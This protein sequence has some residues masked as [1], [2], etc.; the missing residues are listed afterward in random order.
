MIFNEYHSIESLVEE[1]NE[2]D[3]DDRARLAGHYAY[4]CSYKSH[5][6]WDGLPAAILKFGD[7]AFSA[8]LDILVE[9]GCDF[10]Y[11]DA[12]RW[13][14]QYARDEAIAELD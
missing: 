5:G 11:A 2:Y 4:E 9:Y 1:I 13:A 8:N 7:D 12:M 3:P 6:E 10:D 14:Y